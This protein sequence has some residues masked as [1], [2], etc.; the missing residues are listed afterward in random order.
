LE[1]T[2][3]RG[4]PATS[5]ATRVE[6]DVGPGTFGGVGQT[7]TLAEANAPMLEPTDR[8]VSAGWS[9]PVDTRDAPQL[10]TQAPPHVGGWPRTPTPAWLLVSAPALSI[11]LLGSAVVW[12]LGPN[13]APV[14]VAAASDEVAEDGLEP[15]LVDLAAVNDPAAVLP[16]RAR[17]AALDR[18]APSDHA[19]RIDHRLNLA[20]D[21][22]QAG[23]ADEPCSVYAASLAAVAAQPDAYFRRVLEGSAV[24]EGS[25]ATCRGLAELRAEVL[26]KLT[27]DARAEPDGP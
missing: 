13:A 21:L 1:V 17:H 14:E 24:P 2:P 19:P 20:L 27:S 4:P 12:R 16:F 3:L 6:D 25:S 22:T 15:A 23:D 8:G 5:A 18:L 26:A 10:G 11:G 9:G 7:P